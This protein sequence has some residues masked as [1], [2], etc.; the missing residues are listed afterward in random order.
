MKDHVLHLT[1]FGPVDKVFQMRA[2]FMAAQQ[3]P[4]VICYIGGTIVSSNDEDDGT[5]QPKSKANEDSPKL[6]DTFTLKPAHLVHSTKTKP[7]L[8]KQMR[9]FKH[10]NIFA[11]ARMSS[12]KV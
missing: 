2:C 4:E 7:T 9:L 10:M 8:K 3:H 1:E 6:M 5:N 12:L 11:L